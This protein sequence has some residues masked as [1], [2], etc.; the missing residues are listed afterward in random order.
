VEIFQNICSSLGVRGWTQWASDVLGG[1]TDTQEAFMPGNAP[2][3]LRGF[4]VTEVIGN[5][6]SVP[7]WARLGD[8]QGAGITAKGNKH[9]KLDQTLDPPHPTHPPKKGY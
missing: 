8:R 9:E 5:G 1:N 2:V 7:A 3:L 4:N 6:S